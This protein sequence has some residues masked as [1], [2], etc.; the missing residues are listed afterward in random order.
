MTQLIDYI[1]KT[2][3]KLPVETIYDDHDDLFFVLFDDINRF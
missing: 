3:K 2:I 1:L